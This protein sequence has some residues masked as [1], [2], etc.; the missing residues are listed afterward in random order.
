MLFIL[1]F[2]PFSLLLSSHSSEK[3]SKARE[4][5]SAALIT[6][7]LPFFMMSDHPNE[8]KRMKNQLARNAVAYT[9]RPLRMPA[10]FA[11]MLLRL[12]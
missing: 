3:L 11:G 4:E 6:L 8:L 7:N 12:M 2:I 5:S 9:F 10:G 1:P